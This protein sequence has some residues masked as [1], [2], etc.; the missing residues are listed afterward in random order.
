MNQPVSWT[1]EQ[2][3]AYLLIWC[4]NANF[5]EN[6]EEIDFI[7]SKIDAASFKDL[8]REFSKDNDIQRINKITAAIDHF[9]YHKTELKL[10]IEE[11]KE[12]FLVDGKMDAMEQ[13]LLLGLKH[14]FPS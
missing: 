4:A 14:L 6:E 1:K 8:K 5:I 10:L 3:H 11:M 7:L 12:L 2:F 9:N 13:N